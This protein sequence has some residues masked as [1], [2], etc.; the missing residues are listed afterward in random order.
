MDYGC[1]T[2]SSM[3]P[4]G[5]RQAQDDISDCGIWLSRSFVFEGKREMRKKQNQ[6]N[7]KQE[8]INLYIISFDVNRKPSVHTSTY[9]IRYQKKDER[10]FFSRLRQ[11]I[12]YVEGLLCMLHWTQ[13][14]EILKSDTQLMAGTMSSS[15]VKC[16]KGDKR[17]PDLKDDPWTLYRPID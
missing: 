1:G 13:P 11:W 3:V 12:G 7:K 4:F 5:D 14:P 16:I 17:G 9:Q 8:H 15:V 6:C 2:H 10:L